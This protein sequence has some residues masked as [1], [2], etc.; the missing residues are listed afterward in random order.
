MK[1]QRLAS[2][3]RKQQIVE[4]ALSLAKIGNYATVQR[5]EVANA[6][7]VS[8]PAISHH[9]GDMDALREAV[10][11]EAVRRGC[12]PVVVQGL[13][14]G[15]QLAKEAPEELRLRAVASLTGA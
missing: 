4:A 14:A 5:V 11:F 13:A 3:E 6:L 1:K 15:H 9:F 8:P 7:G 2:G 12:L 10:M